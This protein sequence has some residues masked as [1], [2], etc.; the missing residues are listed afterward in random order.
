[1]YHAEWHAAMLF[2]LVLPWGIEAML[3]TLHRTCL[4]MDMTAF[5]H[6]IRSYY[7][8]ALYSMSPVKQLFQLDNTI[9]Y[10]L[11]GNINVIG[12]SAPLWTPLY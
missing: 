12:E 3:A 5:S 10:D 11:L 4:Q 8:K 7:V 2:S 6:C 1:M 9:P